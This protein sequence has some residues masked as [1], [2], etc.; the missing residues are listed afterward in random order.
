MR[1]RSS[2]PRRA[3]AALAA[4]LAT[5]GGPAAEAKLDVVA[6]LPDLAAIAAAVGGDRVEVTALAP[7]SQD[8]HFIDPRPSLMLPLNRADLVVVNGLDLETGWL[9]PLLVG[10]R[11]AAIQPGAPGYF[12]ASRHVE[13][14]EVPA[15]KVDRSQGD[16]H[17][18]GNP[19]YLLDPRAAARVAR[20]LGA[21]MGRLDAEHAADYARDAEAFAA[22]LEKL[23]AAEAA[24]FR[25]LPP[26]RRRVV[27]Y[28]RSMPYL[29]AWLGLEAVIHVEPR[30]GIPPNPAHVARVLKTMKARGVRVI[31][32]EEYYPRKTSETLAR[33]AGAKLVVIPGGA[34]FEE[35]ETY[36]ERIRKV[37]AELYDALAH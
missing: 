23:A 9:A 24:R 2:L 27:P 10:A 15:G 14:L 17:P 16:V 29:L 8:P 21:H 7:P 36:P 37:A 28:H 19:H 4:L 5:A 18:G 32:Q 12:D 34:R 1:A 3:V 30:P 11:N 31:L 25:K 35:G 33:L 6:T 26:E 20:A 13:R 22:G